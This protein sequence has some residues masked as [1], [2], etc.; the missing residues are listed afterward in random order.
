MDNIFITIT[1]IFI[2]IILLSGKDTYHH[3][4]AVR[5]SGCCNSDT[6][7]GLVSL[8]AYCAMD[9]FFHGSL[10]LTALILLRIG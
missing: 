7:F 8:E 2:S 10:C 6:S 1:W 5:D 3:F 4:N 9:T